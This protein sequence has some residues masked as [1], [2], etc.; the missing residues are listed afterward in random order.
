MKANMDFSRKKILTTKQVAER[1]GIK[2]SDDIGTM[3]KNGKFPNAFKA[4]KGWR[5]P[6][7]DIQAYEFLLNKTK[8]CLDIK[9]TAKRLGYKEGRV[10]SLIKRSIFPNAFK[11]NG[12][13]WIPEV[14][15]R[16][17][18]EEKL[19]TLNVH[20]VCNKLNL[21][22]IAYVRYLINKNEFPNAYKDFSG[23]WCIP[24][25]DVQS[26][27][28]KLSDKTINAKEAAKLLNYESRE[29]IINLIHNKFF[30]N[31]YKLRGQ[32][33][34]PLSDINKHMEI[35]N[36]SLTTKQAMDRLGY[37]HTFSVIQLIE[38]SILPNAFKYRGKWRIPLT[39]IESIEEI[40]VETLDTTQTAI[41]LEKKSA[42]LVSEMIRKGVFPNAFKDDISRW[43]IPIRDIEKY[44][45]E[46]NT[47]N[48]V[49][50]IEASNILGYKSV[51]TVLNYLK[52]G[53][54]P[55]SFKYKG[56][57]W[58]HKRDLETLKAEVGKKK[59]YL[60]QNKKPSNKNKNHKKYIPIKSDPKIK[61][62]LSISDIQKQLKL[63]KHQ[64]ANLFNKGIL[65]NTFKYRGRWWVPKS[66]FE[67][68][69]KKR[70]QTAKAKQ[71]TLTVNEAA[72]RLGY[73][74]VGSIS[75]L[76]TKYNKFPNAFKAGRHW[77]IP[78]EDIKD[79]ESKRM[80]ANKKIEFTPKVA[81]NELKEFID[82]IQ[83]DENLHETKELFTEYGLLQ[84]NSMN[85]SASYR[86][87]RVLLYKR[88][89]NKMI[90]EINN[91]I[92]LI[93]TE[94]IEDMLH[95][96][97]PF[98]KGEKKVLIPF[99]RYVYGQKNMDTD[100]EYALV[101]TNRSRINDQDIYSPELFHELYQYVKMVKMHI[102]YAV[103][104]R[105]YANMWVY[106]ILLLT[107]FIRGQDLIMNTPTI[108]LES[109]DITSQDWFIE[110]KLSDFD[111]Q[112]IINQLYLHFRNKRTSKTDELLTF[113]VAPDLVEPLAYALAISELHRKVE[114]SELLLET[115]L[116]GV[117]NNIKTSGKAGHKKFFHRL[118]SAS[119][120][121]FS[122]L[123]MNRTVAT[124]LFYSITE[125]DGQDSDL[126][127][128]LS[129]VSRSHKKADSTSRYIQSTN[130]D[131][132]INRVSYNLFKRGH[133]GWLYNY[134][135]LYVSQF[136]N[137]QDTLEER[138]NLIEKIR[139]DLAPYHLE[140]M[141]E[142]AHN[143]LVPIH[144]E[145]NTNNIET[146]IQNIYK[147][148]QTVIS[149][150][151]R[152]SKEEIREIITKLANGKLPSKNENAQCLV[153]PNCKNPRLS[154][155]F[156]CE[157]VI[158][159]NIMLIQLNEELNRLINSL[160]NLTNEMIIKKESMFLMHALL[161][162]KEARI[163]FGDEKVN[164][165]IPTKETWQE[166]ETIAHKISIE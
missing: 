82:S 25:K 100:V 156:S 3:I 110:N 62:H 32:W 15:I 157:Y 10:P 114:E 1:L 90:N 87:D 71:N 148:R 141:A 43:R 74:H 27:E 35:Q 94:R 131:G 8:Y 21:S 63:T 109:I 60:K 135:I 58:I 30:P 95:E 41:R 68:Y 89:Y 85:G 24:H 37:N 130:K 26:F 140:N 154:N 111:S 107:D 133:F 33:K 75:T 20:Q 49:N 143:N 162:W 47:E 113:L 88:F 80:K 112:L 7:E 57:W 91:E 126:A 11:Y 38:R 138:S 36:N 136:E 39:D 142:Y 17:I 22:S 72:E 56:K 83:I 12:K 64:A 104:N 152:Y 146:F 145:D 98:K 81:Y 2:R 14:D 4:G 67:E 149:K 103:N 150:L 13:W 93:S 59:N 161:I 73:A 155:C 151:K 42:P 44:E 132:S 23:N 127:L 46:H 48:H 18:E 65:S 147:K 96:K 122:S 84:I 123:K 5:I 144:L 102:P 99:L 121:Q 86:R 158:P 106:T 166:I 16:I 52:N 105:S 97:S 164:A 69:L 159:G 101:T 124:Y 77:F 134:L 19:N 115:F 129:Q 76:I 128:H 6:L 51:S 137:A 9:Q 61:N 153:F 50:V 119:D 165:H 28:K 79:F 117:F 53:R 34:I 54:L 55:K 66:I 70:E 116:E 92:F 45:K 29:A 125:E 78:E 139:E 120:F 31:A 108:D 118:K 163:A 40:R 160:K